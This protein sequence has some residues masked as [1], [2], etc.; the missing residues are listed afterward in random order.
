VETYDWKYLGKIA[1]SIALSVILGLF[2]ISNQEKSLKINKNPIEYHLGNM[3]EAEFG[4]GRTLVAVWASWCATCKE[5][6]L[7]MDKLKKSDLPEGFSIIALNID[8]PKNISQAKFLWEQLDIKNIKLLFDK[9]GEYQNTL[10][11]DLLPSYFLFEKSGR[12]LLRLEGQ[13]NWE[14]PK[15]RSLLFE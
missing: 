7:A 14:D 6:L 12:T 3:F 9:S 1:A 13:V 5:D 8:E 10:S 15:L 2:W 4:E 11:V